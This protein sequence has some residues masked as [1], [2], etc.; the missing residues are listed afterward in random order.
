MTEKKRV[1]VYNEQGILEEVSV[2][3][4]ETVRSFTERMA[5]KLGK[6]GEELVMF[7][8]AV[9]DEKLMFEM[10]ERFLEKYKD[11]VIK[12]AVKEGDVF[13]HFKIKVKRTKL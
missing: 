13:E 2:E 11:G 9:D 5:K 7:K 4:G 12:Y 8:E 10:L 1:K 3:E 6:S